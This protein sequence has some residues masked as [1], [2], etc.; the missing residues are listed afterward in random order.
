MPRCTCLSFL[1][2][3][4]DVLFWRRLPTPKDD[5]NEALENQ[6]SSDWPMSSSPHDRR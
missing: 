3:H 4:S 2:T 5:S 1:L 6:A